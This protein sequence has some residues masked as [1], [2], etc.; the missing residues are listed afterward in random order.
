MAACAGSASKSGIVGITDKENGDENSPAPAWKS[1]GKKKDGHASASWA[2]ETMGASMSSQS[3]Q[4]E[5]AS[6]H[7]PWQQTE[8]ERLAEAAANGTRWTKKDFDFGKPLGH[9]MFGNVYMARE[10]RSKW[11]VAIKIIKKSQ[12]LKGN[13]EVQVRREIEIQANLRHPN[14]LRFYGYFQDSKRIYLILEYAAGGEVYSRMQ[15]SGPLDEKTAA[16]YIADLASALQHCHEKHV[17]H[18]DIKPENL[19]IGAFGEIKLADFG[20]SIHSTSSQRLTQ[21]GTPAYFAP[22]MVARQSHDATVDNWCLGVLLYEFLTGNEPFESES[23]EEMHQRISEVDLK[24]PRDVPE[25][26]QELIRKLLQKK[27]CQRLAL[28]EVSA[29]PWIQQN[30][31]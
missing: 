20:W 27:P 2:N 3:P 16:R 15:K 26:A 12:I 23:D 31:T 30:V 13:V 14:I 10:K 25:G 7:Q 29:H 8:A 1:E 11:I 21:C 5:V 17:I 9:G 19:L 28:T 22:E 4:A 18:R 24:F 6:S